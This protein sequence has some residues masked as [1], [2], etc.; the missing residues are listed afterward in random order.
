M[1]KLKPI[2]DA[3]AAVAAC[4]GVVTILGWIPTVLGVVAS[5]MSI[6]WYSFRFYEVY[7]EKHLD[8]E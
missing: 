7:K 6:A 8:N 1:D 2:L 5:L 4:S 3:C